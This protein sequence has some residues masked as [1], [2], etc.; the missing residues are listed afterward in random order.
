M[1]TAD[2]TAHAEAECSNRGT[3]NRDTGQC[4]C[5]EGFIGKA[6]QRLA[7]LSGCNGRGRCVSLS[8]KASTTLNSN[9][10]RY[11]YD[12]VWDAEKTYGC[13]CD[14]GFSGYDC[15]AYDCANGDDPMTTGQVNEVQLIKCTA[16]PT[17]SGS[18]AL[19]FGGQVSSTLAV[20]AT[21]T[22]VKAALEAISGLGTVAV[23]FSDGL[24]AACQTTTT[25]VIKIEFQE[26][27]GS[28]SPLVPYEDD[29]YPEGSSIEIAADGVTSMTSSS[30]TIHYSVKGTKEAQVCANRGTCDTTTGTCQC[31]TDNGD[32]YAS[33]DS[34]G[35]AGIRGDC[36][37]AASSISACPGETSCSGHGTCDSNFVCSC[38][39]GWMGGNCNERVCPTGGSWFSYPVADESAH[40]ELAECSDMGL[41]DRAAGTCECSPGFF[42]EACQYMAC[43]GGTGNAC[44]GHG[45][46]LSMRHLSWESDNDG[47]ATDYQYGLDPNNYATWDSDRIFGCKCDDDWLGYDCSLRKCPY[48]D[49]PGTYGDAREMQLLR[50]QA[51]SGTFQ[52]SFRQEWTT[53]LSY[54]IEIDAL[55]KALESLSTI[56]KVELEFSIDKV[57]YSTNSSY[58]PNLRCGDYETGSSCLLDDLGTQ[59]STTTDLTLEECKAAC[60]TAYLA[61]P[62]DCSSFAFTSSTGTC[63][64]YDLATNST[65]KSTVSA[66]AVSYYQLT[67][68]LLIRGVNKKGFCTNSTQEN[69]VKVYFN[70]PS[71]DVPSIQV[72]SNDLALEDEAYTTSTTGIL[73]I[74]ADGATLGTAGGDSNGLFTSVAGTTDREY[75]SGRGACN[76]ETGECACHIGWGSSDGFGGMGI[77]KDC[78]FRQ[79]PVGAVI[80]EE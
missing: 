11:T 70:N 39:D 42:G 7:C 10:V 72:Y 12:N 52:L 8:E 75:C 26:T 55:E 25:N 49:N 80:L 59:Q 17:S 58:A 71:G 27:F 57:T 21:D 14:E 74:A 76:Y 77:L 56:S 24:A 40:R 4:V 5:M 3:C 64:M 9:S 15:S 37:H 79:D 44:S 34:N 69:I 36:G 53:E 45:T 20:S 62:T 47:D 54:N 6:C 13:I 73:N 22:E 68:P 30:G 32:T 66:A 19:Y 78:G 46:C 51:T 16:D 50:C 67:D 38:S 35:N 43:G 63:A 31:F 28:L 33:S 1:A 65:S 29:L 2:D 48:G 18:F 23:T 41:C 60:Y 61:N